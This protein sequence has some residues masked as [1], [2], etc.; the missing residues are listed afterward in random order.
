MP[1]INVIIKYLFIISQ[2]A[3][4]S[5]RFILTFEA[6]RTRWLIPVHTLQ[7]R[8]NERDGDS[9]HQPH[10]CLLKILFRRRSKETSKLRVTGLCEGDSPVTDEFPAQ[11]ASNAENAS[12]WWRHHAVHSQNYH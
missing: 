7:R 1:N 4:H 11:K 3:Q 12:I 9:N 6:I 2:L 8:Y 10:D 5:F